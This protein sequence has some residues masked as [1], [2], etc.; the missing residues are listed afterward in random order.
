MALPYSTVGLFGDAYPRHHQTG[1][2][3]GLQGMHD[4]SLCILIR[5]RQMQHTYFDQP[6]V[7]LDCRR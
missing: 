6:D 4:C 2:F 7:V 5:S 1:N 3:L